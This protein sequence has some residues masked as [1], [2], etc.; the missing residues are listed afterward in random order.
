M[1]TPN[2]T[3]YSPD[4]SKD[5]SMWANGDPRDISTNLRADRWVFF[6]LLAITCLR[7]LSILA[8]PLE[9]GVDEAQYLSLIH[10]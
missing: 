10:I 2:A 4:N 5:T 6:I 1:A 7:S 8:S 9:L 3:P